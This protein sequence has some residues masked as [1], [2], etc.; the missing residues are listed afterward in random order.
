[1]KIEPLF[2]L[3]E[4]LRGSNLVFLCSRFHTFHA[5]NVDVYFCEEEN[6]LY[7]VK[8]SGHFTYFNKHIAKRTK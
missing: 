1:M 6:S 5:Q 7:H 4:K 8:M 2:D 3:P